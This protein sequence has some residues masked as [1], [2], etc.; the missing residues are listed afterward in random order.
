MLH[1]VTSL[2]PEHVWV[3]VADL[4]F[5]TQE[6]SPEQSTCVLRVE[7]ATAQEPVGVTLQSGRDAQF[8]L[9][10]AHCVVH[11]VVTSDHSQLDEAWQ[12]TLL[13]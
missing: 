12:S 10:K 5:H 7:H 8:V 11:F 3:H 1:V 2:M 6:E 4:L 13:S 9:L